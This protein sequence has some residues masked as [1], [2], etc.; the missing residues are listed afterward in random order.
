[1]ALAGLEMAMAMAMV[2]YVTA[3]TSSVC[4]THFTLDGDRRQVSTV[5]EDLRYDKRTT[6]SVQHR[7]KS[8]GLKLHVGYGFSS[9]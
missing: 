4:H 3:M 5:A 6:D 9:Q 7:Q 2:R 1:M 8:R